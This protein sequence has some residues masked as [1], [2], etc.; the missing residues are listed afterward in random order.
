MN[1]SQ[2]KTTQLPSNH[3]K[4]PSIRDVVIGTL[5]G[6]RMILHRPSELT[7]IFPGIFVICTCLQV[8]NFDLASVTRDTA[9]NRCS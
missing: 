8:S 7:A 5:M 6:K 2:P 1:L 9:I 4:W 3:Y